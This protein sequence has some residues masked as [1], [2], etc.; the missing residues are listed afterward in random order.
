MKTNELR[1]LIKSKLDSVSSGVVSYYHD[2]PDTA[3]YPHVVFDFDNID[4]GD[5]WRKDY[6]LTIDVWDKKHQARAE[7]ISDEICELFGF[8][9]LPQTNLY[10]TFYRE[11]RRNLL[12]EDKDIN[13]TQLSFVVQTYDD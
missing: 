13:H 8:N 6:I 7:A 3:L 10:P 2:V 11:G 5:L 9:N 12:D 1:K 4:L